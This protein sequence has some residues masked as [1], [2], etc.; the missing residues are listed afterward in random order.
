MQNKTKNIL[1]SLNGISYRDWTVIRNEIERYYAKQ[2]GKNTFN[3]DE[4]V[5]KNIMFEIT[6]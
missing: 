1:E 3:S 5:L 4:G 6:Q 2:A